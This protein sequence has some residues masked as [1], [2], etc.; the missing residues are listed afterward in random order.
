MFNKGRKSLLWSNATELADRLRLAFATCTVLTVLRACYIKIEQ[1]GSAARRIRLFDN[2]Y[3]RNGWRFRFHRTGMLI[4]EQ[5][6]AMRI[7]ETLQERFL[8]GDS[9]L[10]GAFLFLC[11]IGSAA[12]TRY[13]PRLVSD[14]GQWIASFGLLAASLPFLFSGGQLFSVVRNS[15]WIRFVLYDTCEISFERFSDLSEKRKCA[16]WIGFFGCLLCV[17]VFCV[18]AWKVSPLYCCCGL[19]GFLLLKLLVAVP[20]WNLV[21]IV[22]IFPFLHSFS[23]PTVILCF[24]VL[25]TDLTWGAKLFCGRRLF[26]FEIVD[27]FVLLFCLLLAFGGIVGWGSARDGL[28]A[29]LLASVYFPT[30]SLLV[31]ALWRR[32]LRSASLAAAFFC[33]GYG[34]LQ[35]FFGSME[36]KWVDAARFSDIG[37]RVTGFFQNPNIL[38]IYLLFQ[39]PMALCGC[40]DRQESF[41]RRLL[42][43]WVAG[44]ICMCTVLTWTRG[45]WLGM[46]LELFL[47]F[48]FHSRSTFA[49]GCFLLPLA[50]F[51]VSWLPPT[52]FRRF[53]SIGQLGES[54]VRY[55]LYTWR[56]VLRMISEHPYGIGVGSEAF[57]AV[58]PQYAFSGIESV[59][60][61][62]QIFLQIAV[63][64][65]GF[66][67]LV[68]LMMLGLLFLRCTV[69][70]HSLGSLYALCGVLVMGLFD[71]LWYCAGMIGLFFMTCALTTV[72]GE[73]MV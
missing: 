1:C 44:M 57:F 38:A 58:Y 9:F 46:I 65:G 19:L 39:L 14:M 71:H 29:C 4:R 21:L 64:L 13:H 56:G 17:F 32:R 70:G 60:H 18:A 55:R 43:A 25:L 72:H 33:S 3:D 47:F 11:G 52:V 48:A 24:A 54:S 45:A 23:H 73:A 67:L 8:L 49:F 63:E 62:H 10:V 31:H 6:L 35:Y 53:A 16:H 22:G 26:H 20:E 36:P 51:A 42:F 50:A 34:I 12:V 69:Y 15:R 5:S 66:G 2:G 59:M 40:F 41:G 28:C 7:S 61:A 68:F 37:G 30:K 27:F